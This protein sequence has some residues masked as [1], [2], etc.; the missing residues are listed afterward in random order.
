MSGTLRIAPALLG[1]GALTFVMMEVQKHP[2]FG[3]LQLV[4]DAMLKLNEAVVERDGHEPMRIAI[5]E[6]TALVAGMLRL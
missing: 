4:L 1:H 6:T 5:D 2:E 3:Q